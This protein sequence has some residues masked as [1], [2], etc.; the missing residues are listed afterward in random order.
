MSHFL[1]VSHVTPFA[2]RKKEVKVGIGT[3]E[4]PSELF[5]IILIGETP[6]CVLTVA[7]SSMCLL[8]HAFRCHGQLVLRQL[9][10]LMLRP[11]KGQC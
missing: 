11:A 9:V 2:L 4:K 7:V 10:H 5:S 6:H 1:F 8:V 3:A